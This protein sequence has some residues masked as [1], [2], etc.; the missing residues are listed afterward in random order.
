MIAPARLHEWVIDLMMRQHIAVDQL[1]ERTGLDP[2]VV[3]AIVY[4]RYTPSPEQ[5]ARV[6][7]A[8][9]CP[10]E[11]VIWGHSVIV[12]GHIHAPD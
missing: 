7:K 6:A 10:P 5:R 9:G 8:L 1:I 2:A 12:E 4:Q 3:E 11:R